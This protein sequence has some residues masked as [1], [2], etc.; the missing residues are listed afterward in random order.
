MCNRQ[1][2]S[3]RCKTV[4]KLLPFSG[5]VYAP[6][7]REN[8]RSA[9]II[10]ALY[11]LS[12]HFRVTPWLDQTSNN[13]IILFFVATMKKAT[14]TD[15]NYIGNLLNAQKC[16]TPSPYKDVRSFSKIFAIDHLAP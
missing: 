9:T 10:S 13:P 1:C 12:N 7:P 6:E 11:L 14:W 3:V 15:V 5:L 16:Y 2:N 8:L 4:C